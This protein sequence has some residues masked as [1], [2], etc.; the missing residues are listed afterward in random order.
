MLLKCCVLWLFAYFSLFSK[1]TLVQQT[2]ICGPLVNFRS[3]H[4]LS[5]SLPIINSITISIPLG[6]ITYIQLK[7]H[8]HSENGF[9]CIKIMFTLVINI[10]YRYSKLARK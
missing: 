4:Y 2:S 1:G 6:W 7:N 10:S 8:P 9:S 5:I 3:K